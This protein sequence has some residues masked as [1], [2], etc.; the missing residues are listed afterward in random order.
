MY[1]NVVRFDIGRNLYLMI[2]F[3]SLRNCVDRAVHA[4]N[5]N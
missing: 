1:L 5:N 2:D 3:Y 4:I